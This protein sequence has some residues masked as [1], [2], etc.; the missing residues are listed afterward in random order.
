MQLSSGE[1]KGEITTF[2]NLTN[3]STQRYWRRTLDTISSYR[4]IHFCFNRINLNNLIKTR[5]TLHFIFESSVFFIMFNTT[6]HGYVNVIRSTT[7]T[8]YL[9]FSYCLQ[10]VFSWSSSFD[11]TSQ[12]QQRVIHTS[13][14]ENRSLIDT[15]YPFRIKKDNELLSRIRTHHSLFIAVVQQLNI[16]ASRK[17]NEM[18][19]TK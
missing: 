3:L 7:R 8:E 4:M 11:N 1:N 18:Q 10:L 15:L 12:Q 2:A 17:H 16:P 6:C 19:F 14:W 5:R 13:G 9:R